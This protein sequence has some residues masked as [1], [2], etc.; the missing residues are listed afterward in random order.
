M[1][2]LR[3]FLAVTR[4]TIR[5]FPTRIKASLVIVLSL[6][7][8][9]AV[10]L[11]LL[12]MGEGIRVAYLSAGDPDTAI[13]LSS[14]ATTDRNSAIAPSLVPVIEG[15][16]GV[17]RLPDG[18]ALA[19]A[20]IEVFA[21]GLPKVNGGV[22]D[23][24]LRGIGAQGPAL[25]PH[26]RLLS[27]RL[28]RENS[29]DLLV[30]I[31]A[32]RKFSDLTVGRAVTMEGQ[33]WSIVGVYSTESFDD[34]DLLVSA[35]RLLQ[36]ERLPRYSLVLA[37]LRSPGSFGEFRHALLDTGHLPLRVERL[38]AYWARLYQTIHDTAPAF[39]IF[40]MVGVLVA[41]AAL[42]GIV[43]V[44]H[45]AV[46]ARFEEIAVLRA[47]GFS[48]VPVVVA[49]LLEALVLACIGA[50]MAT[51]VDRLWL[52]G[53]AYNGAFGV[54]RTAVTF[55]LFFV[56]AAW[57]VVIALIGALLPSVRAARISVVEALGT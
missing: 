22:G 29:N 53:Y 24:N 50:T 55:H 13:V 51:M 7:V 27:G 6:F 37:R 8:V 40:Y 1:T 14:G 33:T 41:A 43:H 49:I 10:L 42:A 47:I 34:G 36:I 3:Q 4:L 11:S 26:F 20:Q 46:S 31:M 9:V 35:Q 38:S 19:D 32:Q 16:P 48:S 15:A 12:S 18:T 56:G 52:E 54:F 17:L 2:C 30:G 45:A 25:I 57:A 5:T 21:Q 39:I 44:M 23:T 28:L